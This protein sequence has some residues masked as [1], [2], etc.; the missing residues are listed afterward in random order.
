MFF[1]FEIDFLDVYFSAYAGI[2]DKFSSALAAPIFCNPGKYENWELVDS[3]SCMDDVLDLSASQ[4]SDCNQSKSQSSNQESD[5][6]KST[7]STANDN[8]CLACSDIHNDTTKTMCPDCN[9]VRK[10]QLFQSSNSSDSNSLQGCQRNDSIPVCKSLEN[11]SEFVVCDKEKLESDSENYKGEVT[12]LS[13]VEGCVT[14]SEVDTKVGN[15]VAISYSVSGV[16]MDIR[17][18]VIESCDTD[19]A[20]KNNE[21]DIEND[22][23]VKDVKEVDESTGI[24]KEDGKLRSDNENDQTF[25]EMNNILNA[26]NHP[27]DRKESNFEGENPEIKIVGRTVKDLL[28]EIDSNVTIEVQNDDKEMNDPSEMYAVCQ[29]LLD[30]AGSGE[31]GNM[32]NNLCHS[33]EDLIS[34]CESVSNDLSEGIINHD[35]TNLENLAINWQNQTSCDSGIQGDAYNESNHDNKSASISTSKSEFEQKSTS[36]HMSLDLATPMHPGYISAKS[37]PQ[38]AA[39]SPV[40][41]KLSPG[42]RSFTPKLYSVQRKI[43]QSPIQLFRHLPIVKNMYM[44]PLLAPDE[45]LQRLPPVHLTVS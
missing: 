25:N 44:S 16:V 19:S 32:K 12:Q 24:A 39:G 26:G 3:A 4:I 7:D 38:K 21:H 18:S 37:S 43:A 15:S 13:D 20:A 23:Q 36:R 34:G 28:D 10:E 27:A 1:T 5:D 14:E 17:N 40:S 9:S 22:K 35:S 11:L 6:I 2:A 29:E 42:K 31:P 45:A 30:D 8:P 33:L 41:P